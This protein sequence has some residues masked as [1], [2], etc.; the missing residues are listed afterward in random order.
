MFDC[1][2]EKLSNQQVER[3]VLDPADWFPRVCGLCGLLL[4]KRVIAKTCKSDIELGQE[5]YCSLYHQ[6]LNIKIEDVF[7]T[8]FALI[9]NNKQQKDY[10][11]L[12][13]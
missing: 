1:F 6:E 11:S 8:F 9:F 7:F 2:D 4:H 5:R 10:Y 13:R 3:S 12:A